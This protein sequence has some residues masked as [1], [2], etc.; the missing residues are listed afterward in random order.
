M[1]CI[2]ACIAA[3][4]VVFSSCAIEQNDNGLQA[5]TP[6]ISKAAQSTPN[7]SSTHTNSDT[8]NNT[9][10]PNS[11]QS[12]STVNPSTSL[13]SPE[14]TE[15]SPT[16]VSSEEKIVMGYVNITANGKTFSAALYDNETAK[17]FV[18]RL[19]LTLNMSELNGN[20][21]YYYLENSLP[22]DSISPGRI[23]SGDLMLYGSDCVV[24]FYESFSTTYR[25]T[26][27][28]RVDN[29][30]GLAQALG[31]GNATVTFKLDNLGG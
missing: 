28:G 24:L 23:N 31:G 20:E 22:V 29:P 15:T 11:E 19:P 1:F 8:E 27:L 14:K 4:I 12:S 18:S 25:Y 2:T 7:S 30:A 5:S 9:A 16:M 6:Q 13:S 3:F 17:A 21:K 26:P 10:S